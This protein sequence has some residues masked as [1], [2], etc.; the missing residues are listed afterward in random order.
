[1]EEESMMLRRIA[2]LG[3]TP[4]MIS[5]FG[6]ACSLLTAAFFAI[7]AGHTLPWEAASP[8]ATSWW[9]F[10]AAV[11]YGLAAIADVVDGHL[12]RSQDLATKFGAV[13]DSTLDRFGE[14]AVFIGCAVYF[15]AH[16]NVTYVLIACIAMT[17]STQI[18]YVKARAENMTTG[19]G[20]GFWQRAERMVALILAGVLGRVSSVLCITALFPMFTVVRRVLLAQRLLGE[21]RESRLEAI[22]D[23][24][25]PWRQRRF[26]APYL[27]LCVAIATAIAVLPWL[28]PF[29]YG[30]MDPLRAV[31]ARL[32]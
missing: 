14:M 25:L 30:V 6:L 19:L 9:P 7:G 16:G 21:S 11:F 26:T 1:M 3:V 24:T 5:Y 29:F 10:Y 2:D 4:N 28:H 20:V 8:A 27:L 15:A 31:M 12:A 32:T 23:R 22:F 18:S 13:L 17:A